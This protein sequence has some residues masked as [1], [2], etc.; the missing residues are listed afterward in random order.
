MIKICAPNNDKNN[1]SFFLNAQIMPSLQHKH[2]VKAS[3]GQYS[4]MFDAD[5]G[6]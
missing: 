1:L 5:N 6:L 2:L 4:M 3:W